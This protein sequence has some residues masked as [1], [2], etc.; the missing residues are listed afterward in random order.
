MEE[1]RYTGSGAGSGKAKDLWTL[2]LFVLLLVAG[3]AVAGLG[4]LLAAR[5]GTFTV[6]ALGV[7]AVVVPASIYPLVGRS[8][9]GA[10]G[11]S[12]EQTELLR[13][14]NDRLLLSDQ[15]KHIAYRQKD[16]DAL[17]QAIIEDIRK[18]DYD[19]ALALVENMAETYGYREEAEQFRTQILDAQAKY[20]AQQVEQALQRIEEICSRFDW[21][22]AQREMQRLQR[23]YPD[24]PQVL[25]LPRRIEQAKADHKHD[26]ERR[27]L[28]AAETGDVDPAVE[29][30]KEL[31][32]YLTPQEA[33][34][35]LETARGVIGQKRENLGVRFK[36][37]VQDKD[38][39]ESVNVGE[40]IIRDFPNSKMSDEVRQMLD[41]LRERAA[42]QRAAETGRSA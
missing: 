20:R 36:L 7:V 11:G 15:A 40:Q 25:A 30:L 19:A 33:E 41:V 16:R 37:A 23:L 4:A 24:H 5:D 35:Y 14:I 17:R 32:K 42:G 22:A 29:L 12:D 27:F 2:I 1:P 21:E 13:S 9:S 39:I 6:L 8:G 3:L 28:R 26:L 10:V 18:Q 38:W 31:D 34:P